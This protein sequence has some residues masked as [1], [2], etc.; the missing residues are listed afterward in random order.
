VVAVVPQLLAR[1]S[2]GLA[3]KYGEDIE[4]PLLMMIMY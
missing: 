3:G 2:A 4:A 1:N